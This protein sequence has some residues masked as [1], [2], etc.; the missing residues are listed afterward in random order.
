M[1]I[2]PANLFLTAWGPKLLDFGTAKTALPVAAINAV[3]QT[4]AARPILTAGGAAVG[5][6]AYMSPE[7]LRRSLLARTRPLPD[8]NRASGSCGRDR[9]GR[10][11]GHPS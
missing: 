9:C 1:T 5:A 4:D 8:G 7:Q 2:K 3:T 6:L 11:G 10:L